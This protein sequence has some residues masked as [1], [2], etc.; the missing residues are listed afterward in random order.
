MDLLTTGDFIGLSTSKPVA[1]EI[2]IGEVATRF[3]QSA[4]GFRAAM[5]ESI[6]GSGIRFL[7]PH[8]FLP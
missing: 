7:L 8:N 2:T 5:E 6:A 3:F 1:F 4:F